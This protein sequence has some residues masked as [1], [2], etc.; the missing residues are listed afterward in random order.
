[1]LHEIGGR[2][3]LGHALAAAQGVEPQRLVVVVR[4][5]RDQVAAV[6][7]QV[8]PQALVADQDD[9]KGTGRAVQC[10]PHAL[11]AALTGDAPLTGT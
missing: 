3:L 5:E 1:M 2:C 6:A 7:E 11:A 9:V 4:H 10:G 8:A